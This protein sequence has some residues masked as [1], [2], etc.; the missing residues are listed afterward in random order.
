MKYR[1]RLNDEDYLRF[2]IFY[3][4]HSKAGKR[5]ERKLRLLCPLTAALFIMVFY[6]A[7]VDYDFLVGEAVVV[8]IIT[9]IWCIFTPQIMNMHIRKHI[10]KLKA[11]GKL[12]YHAD[13][14]IEFQDTM[15]VERSEQGETRINYNDIESINVEKDYLYILYSVSQ[16]LIIPYHCLGK[17]KEQ[18]VDYVMKKKGGQIHI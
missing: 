4:H 1:V 3:L 5:Q 9:V 18:V 8:F 6:I 7:G 11:D 16:G 12:P 17:D 10:K 2:N 13:A 14:E 15:I